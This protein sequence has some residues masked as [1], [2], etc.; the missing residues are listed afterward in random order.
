M[1]DL[2]AGQTY[3]IKLAIADGPKGDRQDDSFD[4]AVFI[5]GNFRAANGTVP[6]P[7]SIALA[8]IA[9]MALGATR[10]RFRAS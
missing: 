5:S 8:G 2:D 1:L 10:R 4:S 7:A 9:L 3:A 6:E